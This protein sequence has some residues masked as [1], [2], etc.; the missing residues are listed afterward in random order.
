MTRRFFLIYSSCKITGNG[1]PEA[2]I[3]IPLKGCGSLQVFEVYN[4]KSN[5]IRNKTF[6][7][8]IVLIRITISFLQRPAR[9]FTNNIVVRF[10]PRLE[11]PGDEVITIICRYPPPRVISPPIPAPLE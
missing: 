5:I 4:F 7:R 1:K 11:F 2:T 8:I 6:I 10:H 3:R 9:V